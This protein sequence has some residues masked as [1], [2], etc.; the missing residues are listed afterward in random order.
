MKK[1]LYLLLAIIWTFLLACQPQKEKNENKTNKYDTPTSGE[2]SVAVDEAFLPIAQQEANAFMNEYE[3][4]KIN[5]IT[6]PEDKAIQL[7]LRDSVD[8]VI[9][10]RN[11]NSNEKKEIERQKTIVRDWVQ[12]YDA[13]AV[14]VNKDVKNTA[15]S[16]E[17]LKS[18]FS[19]NIKNW[20]QLNPDNQDS[21]I[22]IIIDNANSSNYNF[23]NNKLEVSDISKLKIYAAKSNKAIVEQVAKNK[24]ALGLVAFHWLEK[25]DLS[26]VRILAI[27]GEKEEILP[28]QS[29]FAQNT[30]PLRRECFMLVKN[31]RLG[32]AYAFAAFVSQEIG[33]RI[34]LK[35]GLLPA[36]IPP[37]EIE[38]ISE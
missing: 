18:I 20:K 32:L 33:Q 19:G 10:G 30:Y 29:A 9:V 37:R 27:R 26:K 13:V 4:T 23:I 14:V 25:S 24:N 34:V 7:M 15:L 22:A 11:L 21:E 5:I 17:Q 35:S 28:S 3:K 1:I 8:A 12:A 2:I 31:R 16:F 6:L 36:K 38:M